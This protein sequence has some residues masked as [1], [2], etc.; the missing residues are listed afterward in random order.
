MINKEILRNN[1]SV[2]VRYAEIQKTVD[3]HLKNISFF[4]DKSGKICCIKQDVISS[5]GGIDNV[6]FELLQIEIYGNRYHT[7]SVAVCDATILKYKSKPSAKLNLVSIVD[8]SAFRKGYCTILLH[9]FENYL[10]SENVEYYKGVFLPFRNTKS[11]Y[12]FYKKNRCK[13]ITQFNNKEIKSFNSLPSGKTIA[14]IKQKNRFRKLKTKQM[15]NLVFLSG[16]KKENS[17]K[18]S[19]KILEN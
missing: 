5:N 14:V 1:Y 9:T 19:N 2:L 13:F 10:L 18:I 17:L 8:N 15:G 7:K 12:L 16:F 3:K 6:L 4:I 11:T